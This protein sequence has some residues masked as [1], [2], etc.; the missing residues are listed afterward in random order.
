VYSDCPTVSTARVPNGIQVT[1]NSIQSNPI[2]V[3]LSVSGPCASTTTATVPAATSGGSRTVVIPTCGL[4]PSTRPLAPQYW[5]NLTILKQDGVGFVACNATSPINVTG[6]SYPVDPVTGMVSDGRIQQQRIEVYDTTTL[7]LAKLQAQ[8]LLTTQALAVTFQATRVQ[9]GLPS[10]DYISTLLSNLV[11]S[12]SA[13]Y[14]ATV[15][16]FNSTRSQL[17]AYNITDLLQPYNA[18]LDELAANTTALAQ[19]NAELLKNN[20]ILFNQSSTLVDQTVAK[21]SEILLLLPG[22]KEAW[23]NFASNVTFINKVI[24]GSIIEIDE[25][26]NENAGGLFGFFDDVVSAVKDSGVVQASPSCLVVDYWS[27]VCLRPCARRRSRAARSR[28]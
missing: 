10:D 28:S 5:S 17:V 15:S 3:R 22:L 24:V 14:N 16:D 27:F 18:Q 8:Q 1:L 26:A 19:A 23:Y 13:S 20:S 7:A 2:T 21:L 11:A 12:I 9:T 4:V 6:E 25:S